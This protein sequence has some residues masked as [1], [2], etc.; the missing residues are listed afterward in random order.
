M[1]GVTRGSWEHASKI[2]FYWKTYFCKLVE[3]TDLEQVRPWLCPI[4]CD[5]EEDESLWEEISM[6]IQLI[7]LFASDLSLWLSQVHN[8][9]CFVSFLLYSGRNLIQEYHLDTIFDFKALISTSWKSGFYFKS[10]FFG[11]MSFI[12]SPLY[13]FMQLNSYYFPS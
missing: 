8:S 12:F 6:F 9:S 4:L 7:A 2:Y 1:T 11:T 5:P 13:P 10:A 3:D